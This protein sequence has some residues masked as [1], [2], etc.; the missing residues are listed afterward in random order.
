M[1]IN[2]NIYWIQTIIYHAIY[3][4]NTGALIVSGEMVKNHWLK[5]CM[6]SFFCLIIG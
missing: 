6:S 2:V 5:L 1:L 4:A 3:N